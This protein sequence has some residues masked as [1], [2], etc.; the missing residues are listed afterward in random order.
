MLGQWIMQFFKTEVARQLEKWIYMAS[1]LEKTFFM[2]ILYRK[3]I[4]GG[5]GLE[6]IDSYPGQAPVR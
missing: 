5:L 1:Q 6:S 4:A 2:D 3:Q